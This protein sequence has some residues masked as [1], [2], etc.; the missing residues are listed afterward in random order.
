MTEVVLGLPLYDAADT[1]P[2]ALDSLLTQ[3]ERDFALVIADDGEGGDAAAIVER[4][5]ARDARIT[6]SRNP[7]R[8]GLTQNWRRVFELAVEAHP[9][10]RYF[11]WVSD[12]D[13]W[14]PRWLEATKRALAAQPHATMAFPDVAILEDG[15]LLRPR[16]AT[17]D[18]SDV[19]GP[20]AVLDRVIRGRLRAGHMVYGLFRIEAVRRAGGF[21]HVLLAD[22][23]LLSEVA[24]QGPLVRVPEPLWYRRVTGAFSRARQ[25][26]SCFPGR[27]PLYA[28]LPW[29]VVHAAVL[30]RARGAAI[31][32]TYV[33]LTWLAIVES[34]A[35]RYR[36]RL[37]RRL[38]RARRASAAY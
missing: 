36:K 25:R 18:T 5:R 24:L 26:R 32:A 7:E 1:L 11:A 31:A 27:P 13:V 37:A 12:H 20:R 30:L 28:Y 10:A 38:R 19:E 2:E 9:E 23:L 6:Y 33:S 4:Y 3:T 22:R 16:P 35:G 15:G 29:S 8:L 34:A 14:H 21:R 17:R